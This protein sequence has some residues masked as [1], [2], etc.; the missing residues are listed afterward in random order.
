MAENS[1]YAFY[2]IKFNLR[3]DSNNNII[4]ESRESASKTCADNKIA[5][6]YLSNKNNSIILCSYLTNN[7]NFSILFFDNNLDN[8][9][10][11]VLPIQYNYTTLR[12]FFKFLPYKEDTFIFTYYQNIGDAWHPTIQIIK[13]TT[14][15]SDYSIDMIG[16]PIVLNKFDFNYTLMLTDIIIIKE[17]LLCLS[18]TEKGRETLII[19]LINFYNENEYN[20]RYYL[21]DIFK[22]YNHKIF[23][24][25]KLHLFNN[26]IIFGFSFCKSSVCDKESDRHHTSLIIFGY[27]NITDNELYLFDYL[28]KEENNNVILNLF[29]YVNIDNNI[30]GFIIYGIKIYSID[31]CGISFISNKTNEEIK[32]NDTLS[33]NETIILNFTANEYQIKTCS[34]KYRAIATEQ[35]YEQYNK[36]PYYILK[37]SDINEKNSFQKTYYEGKVGKYD[38]IINQELST[39][40]GE[41]NPNCNLCSKNNK[42]YCLKCK[43]GY[44]FNNNVKI[45]NDTEVQNTN[46]IETQ[47]TNDIETQNT[48]DIETQN[49]NDI[50]TQN[51]NNISK[52][53]TEDI[54][55]GKCPNIILTNEEL[56]DMYWHIRRQ[57]ITDNYHY[58]NIINEIITFK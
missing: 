26:N 43:Y 41:E 29:D 27:P 7:K 42:N 55:K 56:K 5:Y 6:C 51:T 50:E 15:E 4:C 44:V 17:N 30:F 20:L 54:A 11:Y 39:N 33:N 23:L 19:V 9:Q 16:S 18:S 58:E 12:I 38:I 21:I 53:E 31:D 48:N 37:E 13:E 3:Y 8:K 57:I 46:D 35:D 52:C 1:Q 25:M 22:L 28:D 24:D 49:T 2:L 32:E 36:Y 45:C 10:E 47:N 34:I 14:A 40:C